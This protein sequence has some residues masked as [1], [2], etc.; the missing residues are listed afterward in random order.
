VIW[1]LRWVFWR[2]RLR[3]LLG[4]AAILAAGSLLSD[5]PDRRPWTGGPELRGRATVV[6]G[7]TLVLRGERIRLDGVDAPESAQSCE[8]QGFAWAC[9]RD[10]T[11]A[12][13]QRLGGR[14]V[15]CA[16][17][18]RDRYG[19]LLARCRVGEE[20]IGAWLVSEG[21]AVAYTRYSWRYMPQQLQA[22]ISGRGLWAGSFDIPEEWRRRNP[23]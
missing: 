8:R 1:L 22:R 6:D 13:R 18:A 19:R 20:D 12:L 16:G 11:Q 23:R 14:E 21:Y 3:L 17:E 10:V 9:G 4:I 2:W 5:R 15:T 7:D